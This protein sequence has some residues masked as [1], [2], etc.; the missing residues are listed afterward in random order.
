M[1]EINTFIFAFQ[2]KTFPRIN[3]TYMHVCCFENLKNCSL[4]Q[5]QPYV[6]LKQTK[7]T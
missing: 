6:L 4:F 2:E 1:H 7:D 5:S 3:S